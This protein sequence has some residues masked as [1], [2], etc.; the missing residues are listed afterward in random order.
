MITG[1]VRKQEALIRLEIFGPDGRSQEIDALV[2]TG[3]NGWPTLP[4]SLI[5]TLKL[6]W[7]NFGRAQLADGNEVD[8]DVY[9][10]TVNWDGRQRLI[11]V[12][13]AD[14]QPLIG[15]ALMEGYKLEVEVRRDGRVTLKPL[16][17]RQKSS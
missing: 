9:R 7:Q 16:R 1:V 6:R 14:V 5:A 17:R 8:C 3:Y 10:A 2:D 13:E 15:M 11:S 4:S 12:A